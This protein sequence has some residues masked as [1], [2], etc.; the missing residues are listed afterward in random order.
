MDE[1]AHQNV[2]PV[3]AKKSVVS[4]P[5]A[6]NVPKA[7]AAPQK[8]K[9]SRKPTSGEQKLRQAVQK[10]LPNYR[11]LRSAAREGL[12]RGQGRLGRVRPRRRR[13]PDPRRASG[14][15]QGE[16]QAGV[17]GQVGGQGVVGVL[18]ARRGTSPP[19]VTSRS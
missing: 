15:I 5:K 4:R 12:L 9:S 1:V 11:V 7:A 3:M 16:G 18:V 6:A 10:V 14:E 2:R 19:E 13:E 8:A 17:G